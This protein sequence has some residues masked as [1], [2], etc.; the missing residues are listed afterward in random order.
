MIYR[1]YA[2]NRS[3][4]HLCVISTDWAYLFLRKCRIF[5][6]A[7]SMFEF[8]G[9]RFAYRT[10]SLFLEFC[11]F[12][13]YSI[14]ISH[15]PRWQR[16]A[17]PSCRAVESGI[18]GPYVPSTVG[19]F[20]IG[21]GRPIIDMTSTVGNSWRFNLPTDRRWKPVQRRNGASTNSRT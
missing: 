15:R 3:L 21:W 14:R 5:S 12:R 9:A 20:R 7:S 13:R 16:Q 2:C 10:Y 1:Y 4:I 18:H 17:H 6:V 11:S 19:Y 8:S